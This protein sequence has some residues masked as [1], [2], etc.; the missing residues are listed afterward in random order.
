MNLSN[1]LPWLCMGDF[2]E[3]LYLWEKA[4]K[5]EADRHRTVAFRDFLDSCSLMDLDSK[6]CKFTWTNNR[7]GADLVKKRLD[8]A[9]CN[10]PWRI[11][12]PSA[13]VFALPV[14]GSDHSPLLL[15]LEPPWWLNLR[16]KLLLPAQYGKS[17]KNET[18]S[19]SKT[20]AQFPSGHL[21]AQPP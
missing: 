3:V 21:K 9:L 12:F 6:C 8:R 14:I 7:E 4:S 19:F 16:P 1:N 20:I 5:R 18:P 10:W 15:T 13:K 11:Q 2:N 17:R